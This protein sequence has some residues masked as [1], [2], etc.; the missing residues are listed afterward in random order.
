MKILN[1]LTKAIDGMRDYYKK[2]LEP[3]R[4]MQE[5]LENS[6]VKMIAELKAINSRLNNAEEQVIWKIK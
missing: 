4:K 1:Q 5:K 3:I 2:E 6:F